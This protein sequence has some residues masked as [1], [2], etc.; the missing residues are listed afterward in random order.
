MDHPC[1]RPLR[2]T[3]RDFLIALLLTVI[4]LL[5]GFGSLSKGVPYWG[6]DFAAYLSEA[7]AIA[8]GDL[9][10]QTQRNYCMHRAVLPSNAEGRSLVYVWG[11]PLLLSLV[12]RT[13]GFD[14]QNFSTLI[15]YK[16]P[17]LICFALCAGVFYLLLRRRFSWRASLFLTLLFSTSGSFLYDIN[18]LYSDLVFL[19]FSL[20]LLL[21]GELLIDRL[22]ANYLSVGTWALAAAL[23]A[24]MWYTYETRLNGVTVCLTVLVAQLVS[25]R[26]KNA[27]PTL[28]HLFC[29]ALPYAIF[30]ALLLIS[31]RFL[32][33][34]TSNLNDVGDTTFKNILLNFAA[35]GYF[36]LEYLDVLPGFH[37][38]LFLPAAALCVLGYLKR[39]FQREN[40]H[41]SLLTLGTY[42]VN[43]L[44]PYRQGSRYLYNIF[45]LLIIYLGYG[46]DWTAEKLLP[47][48]SEKWRIRLP[49]LLRVAGIAILA[50]ACLNVSII[51]IQNW[52]NA[53]PLPSTDVYSP[54]AVEVYRYLQENTDP[55]ELICF[56]KPR[57]L[58]LNTGR[59]GFCVKKNGPAVT[60][61][62]YYLAYDGPDN[63]E[64]FQITQE[65]A[66]R[67]EL[68][69]ATEH[70]SLYKVLPENP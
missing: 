59:M 64:K 4:V 31:S 41:L 13:V 53:D 11:Y 23:G 52:T 27:K 43:I 12:Y 42:I 61:A 35:Y 5:F 22:C 67:F 38:L 44:L 60:E 1:V 39:G 62:D 55:D 26:T 29:H 8:D 69:Y 34:A 45:P 9:P 3:K 20:L 49:K 51:G 28:H 19:F 56:F 48:L 16:F 37:T 30:V 2:F 32:P 18:I 33:P 54:E 46:A 66:H 65:N 70:F 57:A 47:K 40:L 36:T 24:V 10:A 50:A 14:M 17:S 68:E 6:D 21:L 63:R 15:Y 7:I 58:Y 25:L